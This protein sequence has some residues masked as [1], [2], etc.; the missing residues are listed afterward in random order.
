MR[1]VW[2]RSLLF[3]TCLIL[4]MGALASDSSVR[5]DT[6]IES[7]DPAQGETVDR[8]PEQVRLKLAGPV[9]AAFSP[10]EVYDRQGRR[11][12]QDNARLDPEDPTII[13]IDLKDDL[14]A[15]SY[16]VEY[17]YTGEDGHTLSGSYEFSVSAAQAEEPAEKTKDETTSALLE[18]TGETEEETTSAEETSEPVEAAQTS[19]DT[20]GFP[21]TVL[22]VG[23]GVIGLAALG[24]LAL[25]QR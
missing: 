1:I 7:M 16:T 9:D 11:V 3:V 14:P 12:D 21:T 10:L 5:A 22:L 20:S 13:V 6:T 19:S 18:T 23:L 8:P 17:R 4:A 2:T 15:G 25:R 24:M